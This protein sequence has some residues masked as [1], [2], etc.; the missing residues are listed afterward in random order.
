VFIAA[1]ILI[2]LIGAAVQLPGI[3]RKEWFAYQEKVDAIQA[4][5]EAGSLSDHS[6][7]K[8]MEKAEKA[9][10]QCIRL[11]AF[12]SLAWPVSPLVKVFKGLRFVGRKIYARWTGQAL[13]QF[14][15]VKEQREIDTAVKQALQKIIEEDPDL[16][17]IELEV[18]TMIA[19][20]LGIKTPQ[21]AIEAAAPDVS[22]EPLAP[23]QATA[24]LKPPTIR[25]Y[26]DDASPWH[27]QGCDCYDC[28]SRNVKDYDPF[29]K[30]TYLKDRTIIDG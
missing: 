8:D 28:G 30:M 14:E 7:R 2:V 26:K 16:S 9:R 11:F 19:D 12:I 27:M 21:L 4:E 5:Y 17:R 10:K 22:N 1:L 20:A 23:V 13:T 15:N 25:G 6:R 3:V 24:R 18:R 29:E